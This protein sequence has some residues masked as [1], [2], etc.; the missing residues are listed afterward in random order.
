[1]HLEPLDVAFDQIDAREPKAVRDR[2]QRLHRNGVRPVRRAVDPPR[3]A[4]QA[5]PDGT[6]RLDRGQKRGRSRS[7]RDTDRHDLDLTEPPQR[8]HQAQDPKRVGGW[9]DGE[10]PAA[11]SK[12]RKELGEL[13]G[14]GA[15]IEDDGIGGDDRPQQ[16]QKIAMVLLRHRLDDVC[17]T[18]EPA[19]QGRTDHDPA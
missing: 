10:D 4:R 14:M 19:A 13:A 11:R 5:E 17:D 3:E 18:V 16:R 15:D 12:P 6:G 7:V 2:V 8:D 9:L 1:M